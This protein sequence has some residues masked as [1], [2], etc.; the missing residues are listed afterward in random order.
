MCEFSVFPIFLENDLFKSQQNPRVDFFQGKKRLRRIQNG[1]FSFT[2]P[3]FYVRWIV[4]N[5]HLFCRRGCFIN[6][7][8]PNKKN[9]VQKSKYIIL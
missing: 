6:S 8:F 1:I 2:V 7:A 3:E 5:S 4:Y 9:L